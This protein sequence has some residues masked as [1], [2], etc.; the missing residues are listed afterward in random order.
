[1]EKN[2]TPIKAA[3][4]EIGAVATLRR[5]WCWM[6]IAVTLFLALN[7]VLASLE[8]RDLQPPITAFYF[9]LIAVVAFRTLPMLENL[10]LDVYQN[11]PDRA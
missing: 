7:I 5:K 6:S 11:N 3:R 1:M 9:Q 8:M 4:I 2:M 10:D